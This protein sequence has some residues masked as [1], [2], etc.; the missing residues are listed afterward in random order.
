M[1][2][3]IEALEHVFDS[4]PLG[5]VPTLDQLVSKMR[6]LTGHEMTDVDGLLTFKSIEEIYKKLPPNSYLDVQ[7]REKTFD[8]LSMVD[9]YQPFL[10]ER[11]GQKKDQTIPD[12]KAYA[13]YHLRIHG[14]IRDTTLIPDDKYTLTWEM[15]KPKARDIPHF[16][17]ISI[18]NTST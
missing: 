6:Q 11:R 10:V 8:R 14:P 1:A 18:D 7:I 15:Q 12:D 9:A 5:S 16:A 13:T 4:P 2:P 3:T 17:L